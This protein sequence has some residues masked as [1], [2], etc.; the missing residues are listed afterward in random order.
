MMSRC[1]YRSSGEWSSLERGA[2]RAPAGATP[3]TAR[4]LLALRSR[5]AAS[6]REYSACHGRHTTT[7]EWSSLERGAGATPATARA[8][9]ALRS[10]AAASPRE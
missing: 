6:P 9:L 2:G 7:G 3:A 1:R 5:T 10:R 4:A 8:L